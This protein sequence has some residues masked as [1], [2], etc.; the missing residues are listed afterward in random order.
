MIKTICDNCGRSFSKETR[1]YN[2]SE[3]HG[4]NHYCSNKCSFTNRNY[5][6]KVTCKQCGINFLKRLY[7]IKK[8]P[9]HFCSRSCAV[10]YNNTHKKYG[11][12]I[13]KLELWLAKEL[14]KFYPSLEFHFTRKDAI[15]S[16]LDIYIPS[17]KLAFELNG[18]F[19]YEPIY[20]KDKLA[21][22]INNDQRKFQACIENDIELCIID[23]SRLSHFKE[24]KANKYL[25]IIRNIIN[26]KVEHQENDSC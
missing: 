18:I 8:Y 24:E 13:S 20:G 15:N 10:T 3:K 14:P 9:N 12:K 7:E 25:D 16:E 11:I 19:H 4:Y 6:Q 23:V 2:Q 21:Q 26:S 22:I 17:L 5:K 1:A